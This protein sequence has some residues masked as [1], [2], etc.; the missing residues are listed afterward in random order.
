VQ[1][2]VV[3]AHSAVKRL[4]ARLAAPVAVPLAVA[5]VGFRHR[6]IFV[7]AD[8]CALCIGET[9]VYLRPLCEVR[10]SV[11]RRTGEVTA[12]RLPAVAEAVRWIDQVAQ[13]VV[14]VVRTVIEGVVEATRT[15]LTA[16][17]VRVGTDIRVPIIDVVGIEGT[18][19]VII[20]VA[21]VTQ[22]VE[23]EVRTIIIAVIRAI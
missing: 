1:L 19:V 15:V 10:Q 11:A 17:G 22:S 12:A 13:T 9:G 2:G 8:G 23:I 16:V 6:D 7:V 5:P 3:A 21:E 4:D 20:W 14:V 18:V